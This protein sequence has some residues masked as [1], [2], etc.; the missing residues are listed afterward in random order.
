MN[1]LKAEPDWLR[2]AVTAPV[3]AV[4]RD[5]GLIL[6]VI[7]AEEGVFHDRRGEFDKESIRQIVRLAKDKSG[8]LKARLGHPSMSSD[9]LGKFVGRM[10]NPRAV[11]VMRP[12]GDGKFEEKLAAKF[13]LH[14]S[15]SSRETPNGDIGG[16]VMR[17]AEED[18]EAFGASLVLKTDKNLRRDAKGVTLKDDKGE[19][20]PPLWMPTTLHALDVVDTPAATNSFL[21]VDGLPDDV[22]RQA[23]E[24]LD[25]QFGDAPRDVVDRRVREWLSRYLDWRY[26][27]TEPEKPAAGQLDTLR[28]KLRLL[29]AS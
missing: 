21:S 22:L 4:D 3:A 7:G 25:T 16:Y 28:R 11:P 6:G 9:A 18:P 8:G 12:V 1:R 24:L 23:C 14:V 2:A 17:L 5:K 13:D 27:D 29:E 20:L 10:R 15:E 19:D 26:G